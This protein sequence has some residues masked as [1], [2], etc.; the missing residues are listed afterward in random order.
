MEGLH[1]L[2]GADDLTSKTCVRLSVIARSLSNVKGHLEAI[3]ERC[4]K[5]DIYQLGGDDQ[6]LEAIYE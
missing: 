4:L 2:N 5:E 6:Y 3:Y 1:D